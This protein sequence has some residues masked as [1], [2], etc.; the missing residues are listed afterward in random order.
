MDQSISLPAVVYAIWWIVLVAVV[1]M[2][3]PLA[4]VLLHRT[5]RAALSIRRY[6]R[7]MLQAGVGIAGNTRSISTLRD[8]IGV[9]GSMVSTTGSI[10]QHT[11]TI[12]AVLSERAVRG[13]AS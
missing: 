3:V 2:I 12:A 6:L 13:R 7:E 10:K 5:L 9:A 11:D 8:T 4:V 1:L